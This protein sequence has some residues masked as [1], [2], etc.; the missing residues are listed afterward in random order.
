M[1]PTWLGRKI[2]HRRSVASRAVEQVMRRERMSSR[3]LTPVHRAMQRMEVEE[4]L[5]GVVEG[6]VVVETH[7]R[8][9]GARREE[10]RVAD[11]MGDWLRE[12]ATCCRH[13]VSR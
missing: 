4:G 6:G 5:S 1:K 13:T 10:R 7:V 11:V 12:V 9:R 8:A 3:V 2:W